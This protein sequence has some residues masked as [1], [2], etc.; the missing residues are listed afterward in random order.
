[1]PVA[2]TKPE[3]IL[4]YKVRLGKEFISAVRSSVVVSAPESHSIFK[5]IL[6][7]SL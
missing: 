6:G 7:G 1:M 3:K 4:G 2:I 5:T